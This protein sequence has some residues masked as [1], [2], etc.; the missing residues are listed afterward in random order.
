LTLKEAVR[1]DKDISAYILGGMGALERLVLY[2]MMFVFLF[3]KK[4]YIF[5]LVSFLLLGWERVHCAFTKVLTVYQIYCTE[6]TLSII[7]LYPFIPHSWNSFN[8]FVFSVKYIERL[9]VEN[10]KNTGQ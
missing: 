3:L 6:F 10:W 7:L 5:Y 8:R 1:N 9:F 2:L 4:L